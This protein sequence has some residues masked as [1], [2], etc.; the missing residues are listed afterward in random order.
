V[1]WM[2]SSRT[3]R[4]CD[5]PAPSAGHMQFTNIDYVS[6]FATTLLVS[7]ILQSS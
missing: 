4:W 7:S 3:T 1:T 5:P 6:H 2:R